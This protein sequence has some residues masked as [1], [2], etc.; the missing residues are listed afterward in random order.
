VESRSLYQA[1]PLCGG[2][3]YVFNRT[4]HEVGVIR[5]NVVAAGDTGASAPV[6]VAI[7]SNEEALLS[8][9]GI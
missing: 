4:R 3:D 9:G 2:L 6:S 5:M 1:S 7:A 8:I